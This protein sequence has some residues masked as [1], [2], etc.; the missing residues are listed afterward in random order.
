MTMSR[1]LI[2]AVNQKNKLMSVN[3]ES[4]DKILIH[5]LNITRLSI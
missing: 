5:N 4:I 1:V 2:S 3:V